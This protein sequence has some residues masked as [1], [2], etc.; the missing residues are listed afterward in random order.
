MGPFLFRNRCRKALRC[1]FRQTRL[2]S[3]IDNQ[4]PVLGSGR[5][6]FLA[7]CSAPFG[8]YCMFS[9]IIRLLEWPSICGNSIHLPSGETG[10][11]PIQYGGDFSREKIGR[12]F[13]VL[14]SYSSIVAL[15]FRWGIKD[16]PAFEGNHSVPWKLSPGI[17]CTSSGEE[18]SAIM[19]QSFFF[20]KK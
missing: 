1:N 6:V 18:P 9:T 15:P 2:L 20:R 10:I 4:L 19:R 7:H 14:V 13:W 3:P 8:I 12:I 5:K 16:I 17:P 11:A